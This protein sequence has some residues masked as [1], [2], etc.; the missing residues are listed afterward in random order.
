MQDGRDPW[1]AD[2]V[3]LIGIRLNKVGAESQSSIV[4]QP[5]IGLIARAGKARHMPR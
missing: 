5:S 4:Y 2:S 1:Q 3:A